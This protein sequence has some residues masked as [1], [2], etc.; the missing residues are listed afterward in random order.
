MTRVLI[1]MV[2][3]GAL[4][5]F[6]NLW[7]HEIKEA[8]PSRPEARQELALH[9]VREFLYG[10]VFLVTAWFAWNG[11][12]ATVLIT[13]LGIEIFV[14]LAD[15]VIEDKTRKLPPLERV[16]HAIL[17]LNYGAII[18]L[19]MPQLGIW[20]ARDTAF[21]PVSYGLFSWVL[22]AYGV[23]VLLW[24][25][26]NAIATRHL[27]RPVWQRFPVRAG[28]SAT[29]RT[30]IITG[31]TGFIGHTLT[32][33]LIRR[34]DKVIVLTRNRH[35]A[36]HLFGRHVDIVTDL[37]DIEDGRKI[38]AIINLAGAPV[39]GGLWTRSRKA[40]LTESRVATTNHVVDL[41]E[42]LDTKP[43]ILVSG[44]AVGFYGVRANDFISERDGPQPIFMSE[45]CQAWE[46][47]AR[48]AT[49]AGVRVCTLRTGLVLG[50]DGGPLPPMALGA[51]L[52]A[53]MVLGHGNQFMPWILKTD[54]VR[55]IEFI[56]DTPAISGPL[57]A[58]API[59][60]TN[61]H[62]MR[63]LGHSLRRPVIFRLPAWCLRLVLGEMADLFLT[64]QRVVPEKARTAGF[65]FAA[66]TPRRALYIL[67]RERKKVR[68]PQFGNGPLRV[69][70]ND[71]CPICA[72][73]MGHYERLTGKEN[74]SVVF[75]RLSS[76]AHALA[77]FGLTPTDSNRRLYLIDNDGQI[78]GGVDAFAAIW[79]TLP[80]Y[81][82]L[83]RGLRSRVGHLFGE[84]LY[85]GLMV[86]FLFLWNR[87][88][89]AK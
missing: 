84:I 46:N 82:W 24:S 12:W 70:Y 51:R 15:F 25:L 20:F 68:W 74:S 5:A 62:F 54:L 57:N 59:P 21:V 7:H 75:S 40:H 44:S 86:P 80:G 32:R 41:I 31:A 61:R 3:Q 27:Y 49:Q 43:E 17:A 65:R 11:L 76:D 71:S 35:K 85:D 23:V 34:G 73:E 36:F 29:P 1:L 2:I 58:T 48:R 14:T 30:I 78:W 50:N 42:R 66:R 81:R 10:I 18:A 37:N 22:T 79:A 16:T 72:A 8:L 26:R 47:A 83:S 39:M 45:M 38:D 19:W 77:K 6:D 89:I 60:V 13:I 28:D 56:V 87:G 64:G 88:R 4:G 9:A 53:G 52:F 69:F 33:S 55:L 67:R 63:V